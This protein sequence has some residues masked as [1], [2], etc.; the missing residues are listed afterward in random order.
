MYNVRLVVVL[1]CIILFHWGSLSKP[2]I[3]C[4]SGS[5][6]GIMASICTCIYLS[7]I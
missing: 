1:V 6:I 5:L 2:H 7:I 3:D 4:G